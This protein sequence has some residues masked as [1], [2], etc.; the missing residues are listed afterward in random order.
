MFATCPQA[1]ACETTETWERTPADPGLFFGDRLPESN[2]SEVDLSMRSTAKAVLRRE[3]VK[4]MTKGEAAKFSKKTLM[5]EGGSHL[6]YFLVRALRLV[7]G[8]KFSAFR[9]GSAIYI[10]HSD[11]GAPRKAIRSAVVVAVEGE[12]GDV[13]ISCSTAE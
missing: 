13:F 1:R 8:G 9:H 10:L 3:A 6:R 2:F 5:A 11:I 7:Q 4:E 12:I